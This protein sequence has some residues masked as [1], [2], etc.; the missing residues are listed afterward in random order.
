MAGATG[1]IYY[2]LLR[3]PWETLIG[4][5]MTDRYTLRAILPVLSGHWMHCTLLGFLGCG[6]RGEGEIGRAR[7]VR[8]PN[9][10]KRER[11]EDGRRKAK[12]RERAKR[13]CGSLNKEMCE[14]G[15]RLLRWFWQR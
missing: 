5:E 3:L 1:L 12:D 6:G 10:E 4:P 15:G 14:S 7:E 2:N 9:W 13:E 11:W 8:R